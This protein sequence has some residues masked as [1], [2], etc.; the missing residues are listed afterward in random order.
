MLRL[1]R[2][3]DYGTVILSHMGREPDGVFSVAG[4]ASALGVTPPTVSKIL[5][6]LVKRKLVSS[7]RGSK[8]GYLLARPPHEISVAEVIDALENPF[9]LTECAVAEGRCAREGECGIR[10]QWQQINRI[11][12]RS[13]EEVTLSD[14][15]ASRLPPTIKDARQGHG[16]SDIEPR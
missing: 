10:G 4:L 14:L 16:K 9:G 5:K 12:R 1:S 13:L 2:L 11:V 15:N 7:R 6:T 8:G 3:T